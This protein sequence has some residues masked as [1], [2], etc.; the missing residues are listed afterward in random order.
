[1]MIFPSQLT[2]FQTFMLMFAEFGGAVRP[3]LNTPLLAY[4]N[5]IQPIG[6]YICQYVKVFI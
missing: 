1:M 3:P 5:F 4:L 6:A 2:K